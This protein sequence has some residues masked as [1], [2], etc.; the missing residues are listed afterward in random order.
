MMQESD[1]LWPDALKA[2]D[3]ATFAAIQQ[4]RRTGTNLLVWEN[5]KMV[6]ITPDQAEAQMNE[7]EDAGQ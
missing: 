1:F 7:G 4:A 5:G 3:A 2:I 6:E